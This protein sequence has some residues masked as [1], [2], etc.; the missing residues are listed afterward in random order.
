[1]APGQAEEPSPQIPQGGERAGFYPE[2]V[3]PML[4][5]CSLNHGLDLGFGWPGGKPGR[6]VGKSILQAKITKLPKPGLAGRICR[7]ED[8]SS[9]SGQD[10]VTVVQP[11]EL[12]EQRE[13]PEVELGRERETASHEKHHWS[14][15]CLVK[16][17]KSLE[18][19]LVVVIQHVLFLAGENQT[20]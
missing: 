8:D 14:W 7:G 19:D 10:I 18:V 3:L 12:S 20:C 9:S 15:C 5:N 1:M 4:Q 2:L 17:E 11:A 6:G 13:H 16:A